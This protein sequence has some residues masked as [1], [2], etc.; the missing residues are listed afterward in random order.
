MTQRVGRNVIL[1]IV[2]GLITATSILYILILITR[3]IFG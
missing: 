2:G 1:P 3:R